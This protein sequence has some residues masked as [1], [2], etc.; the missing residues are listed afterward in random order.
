MAEIK[1]SCPQCGQHISGNE[2]WSG[3]QI[4]CPTCATTLT[5]P[6]APP[7]PAAAAPAPQSLVPSTSSVPRPQAF[8]RGDPGRA[9]DCPGNDPTQTTRGAPAEK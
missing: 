1:F 6:R 4:Q 3:H 7:P 9:F 2:Q 5:V 8:C